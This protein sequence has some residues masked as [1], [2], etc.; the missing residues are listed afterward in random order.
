MGP[1][2]TH[3]CI[4]GCGAYVFLPEDVRANKLSPKSE[5]IIYLGQPAGYKGYCFYCITNEQI[6][7]GATTVFD[8]TYFPCC[9]DG[10]Q[11]LFTELGD[12]LPTEN[13]YLDDPIDQSDDNNFGHQPPFPMANDN[14]PPSSPPSE[15]EVPE[16]SDLDSEHPSQ[17]Q[18]NPPAPPPRWRDEELQRCGTR[19]QTVMEW[20]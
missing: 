8:E 18:G 5:T 20:H 11:R 12:K 3:L 7:I 1:C 13:R 19:Q 14:H 6:F 9:S 17:T 2:N 15:P 16:V 10:K 4:F